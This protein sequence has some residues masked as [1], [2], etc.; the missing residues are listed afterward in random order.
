MNKPVKDHLKQLYSEWFLAGDHV[1]TPTGKIKKLNVGSMAVPINEDVMT[2]NISR[3]D[4]G[5]KK[6][7]I[8]NVMDGGEGDIL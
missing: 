5:F 3:S 6:R 7:C 1:L 2:M 4:E 8:S